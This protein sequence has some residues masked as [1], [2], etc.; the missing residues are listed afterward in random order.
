MR[1]LVEQRTCLYVHG[2]SS[3]KGHKLISAFTRTKI[4]TV[5]IHFITTERHS[6]KDAGATFAGTMKY[7]APKSNY[8]LCA[9]A[10]EEALSNNFTN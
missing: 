3:C 2:H 1:E 9:A 5:L 4:S 6:H 8:N 7:T 10:A